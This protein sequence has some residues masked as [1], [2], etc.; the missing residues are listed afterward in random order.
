MRADQV[1]GDQRG[2]IEEQRELARCLAPVHLEHGEPERDLVALSD[3]PVAVEPEGL[4][5]VLRSDQLRSE[6]GRD[7][8][9]VP[10]VIRIGHHDRRQPTEVPKVPAVVLGQRQRIDGDVPRLPDP[11]PAVEVD[12]PRLV[13]PRPAEEV[14]A[15]AE[16]HCGRT[17]LPAPNRVKP[18]VVGYDRDEIGAM[19][20]PDKED[21]TTDERAF[22]A[23]EMEPEA[24][25]RRLP[26]PVVV[27][28]EEDDGPDPLIGRVL[29]GLYKVEERIGEGGMGAVYAARHVHLN[30]RFAI[31]VLSK[32]IAEHKQAVERLRQ[33]AVA[34][35]S[36]D[37]DNIVS[38][39]SFDT[40]DDGLVFIVME[41]LKGEN[42]GD[43]IEK[44]R[45]DLPTA[46]HISVQI[47]RAL[48]AA[49]QR[50]IVHRDLK[51]ENVF[52]VTKGGGDFVKVLDF[53][54]SKVKTA[55]TEQVRMTKTGQLVGTPLYMSPEQAK[56]EQDVD[57]RTD[58]YALGVMM[59]EMLTGTPPFEG[60]NYFQLL[61]KHGNETPQPARG[62]NSDI[63][64]ALEA[65]VMR[66]LEKD[67]DARFDTMAEMEAAIAQA[68]PDL[69]PPA[70]FGSMPSMP[71]SPRAGVAPKR[72]FAG[73]IAAVV[74]ATAVVMLG[75]VW[76]M[77]DDDE[78]RPDETAGPPTAV[79]APVEGAE[80][81]SEE[82]TEPAEEA[83]EELPAGADVPATVPVTFT[84]IP[85]GATVSVAGETLGETPLVAPVERGDQPI[86][87]RFSLPRHH[88]HEVSIVPSEPIPVEGRLRPVRARETGGG[89]GPPI[90]HTL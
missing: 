70:H 45:I 17:M 84:S 20:V 41:L 33:E 76:M 24:G 82:E 47:C 63:P 30:K 81:A 46:V 74:V 25:A 51:P 42:L 26:T 66:A 40:T 5:L 27:E 39:V 85:S 31:K 59:Y 62:R 43:L 88:D 49:H 60:G 7:V 21:R 73:S 15:V 83:A 48:D 75:I 90:K 18:G 72:S 11:D 52:V 22:A 58:V 23:T 61:W 4:A 38:V 87:V 37:H 34:A 3:P 89:P 65:V 64:P 77:Q 8:L 78:I 10:Q 6:R 9:R 14:R 68:V 80:G 36:I 16:L 79:L 69:V 2:V 86:M 32:K 28:D 29:G 35:S 53:G 19:G 12:V 50:G 57:R 67:P 71:G 55:E 44:G 54:I 56:G 13:E 1:A